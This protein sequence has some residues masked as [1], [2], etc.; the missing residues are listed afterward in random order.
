MQLSSRIF[1]EANLIT[2]ENMRKYQEEKETHRLE[3]L[4]RCRLLWLNFNFTFFLFLV[5]NKE[6]K[7]EKAKSEIRKMQILK[8]ETKRMYFSF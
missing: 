5:F 3:E 4:V 8:V 1:N 6:K 7:F 2:Q